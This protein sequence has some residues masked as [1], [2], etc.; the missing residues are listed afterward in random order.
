MH[1]NIIYFQEGG[2]LFHLNLMGNDIE[3][4]GAELIAKALH[5]SN[6]PVYAAL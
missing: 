6:I 1:F 5:V 4:D 2:S 3:T